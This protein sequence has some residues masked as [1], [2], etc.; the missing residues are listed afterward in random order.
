M[1]MTEIQIRF[2]VVE[3]VDRHSGERVPGM[4]VHLGKY[5]L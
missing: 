1:D 3:L 2:L 4:G 5:L